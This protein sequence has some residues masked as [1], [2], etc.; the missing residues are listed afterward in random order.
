MKLKLNILAHI[1][2]SR[3]LR[4]VQ[5]ALP[6]TCLTYLW[7]ISGGQAP[8]CLVCSFISLPLLLGKQCSDACH[9]SDG[10]CCTLESFC[11]LKNS[12]TRKYLRAFVFK[13]VSPP[14]KNI[15]NPTGEMAQRLRVLATL[16]E[17]LAPV[18]NKIWCPLLV[19]RHICT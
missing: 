17:V 2:T 8:W 7:G 15:S 5:R 16:P 19:C 6:V 10:L 11:L 3:V 4:G 14:T 18:Y 9:A 1:P 12:R 13:C